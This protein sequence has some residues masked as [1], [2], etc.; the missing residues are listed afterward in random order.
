MRK[1]GLGTGGSGIRVVWVVRQVEGQHRRCWRCL[2]KTERANEKLLAANDQ[3]LAA[4]G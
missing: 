1:E 2:V 3:R 4:S